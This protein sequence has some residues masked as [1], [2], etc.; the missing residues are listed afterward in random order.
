MRCCAG[1]GGRAGVGAGQARQLPFDML[2]MN[3]GLYVNPLWGFMTGVH[4]FTLMSAF[5]L[6]KDIFL[7]SVAC[8][9]WPVSAASIREPGLLV[10]SSGRCM[11][12]MA[13]LWRSVGHAVRHTHTKGTFPLVFSQSSTWR[14]RRN[15]KGHCPITYK[16]ATS[17]HICYRTTS[18]FG[19]Q[20][21][22]IYTGQ[23]NYA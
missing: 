20:R 15:H 1:V 3:E 4:L 9:L 8:L 18:Q 7:L 17:P 10:C 14:W 21:R 2:D 16:H 6:H 5:W 11:A 13:L 19:F 12:I 22:I 23:T